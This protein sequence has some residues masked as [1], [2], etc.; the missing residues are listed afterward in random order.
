MN[1]RWL[2]FDTENKL[3]Q[4][5]FS[6]INS[7]M[8]KK[9]TRVGVRLKYCCHTTAPDEIKLLKKGES[10]N[11]AS[12]QLLVGWRGNKQLRP[13]RR[14]KSKL[15]SYNCYF[16]DRSPNTAAGWEPTKGDSIAQKVLELAGKTNLF[17]FYQQYSFPNVLQSLSDQLRVETQIAHFQL[18]M[19]ICWKT[20]FC[21]LL[22]A[23]FALIWN[24]LEEISSFGQHKRV[25]R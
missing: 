22:K 15:L 1:L 23:C 3:K 2:P 20:S 4:L 13:P 24:R 8:Y 18:L 14:E 5:F 16:A 17:V 11:Q 10:L 9:L 6:Q 19:M 7:I 25:S 21:L 12:Y